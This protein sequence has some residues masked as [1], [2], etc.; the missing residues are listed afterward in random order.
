MFRSFMP[1]NNVVDVSL[2]NCMQVLCGLGNPQIHCHHPI[3]SALP[4]ILSQKLC[5]ERLKIS[6]PYAKLFK[7]YTMKAYGGVDI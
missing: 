1:E 6:C 7:H 4:A 3:I 2:L 5:R